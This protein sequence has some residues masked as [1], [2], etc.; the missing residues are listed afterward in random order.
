LPVLVE[1]L[2]ETEVAERWV[3]SFLPSEA[4]Q[5]K[6]RMGYTEATSR[7]QCKFSHW[8]FHWHPESKLHIPSVSRL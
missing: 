2:E 8:A 1:V 3:Q 6:I 4:R 7:H 5:A